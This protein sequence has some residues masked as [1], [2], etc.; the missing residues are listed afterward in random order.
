MRESL[1]PLELVL[2][3]K[4]NASD[5]R[6]S[7]ISRTATPTWT[8]IPSTI[9]TRERRT[10][11][12]TGPQTW[13]PNRR[14]PTC[15]PPPPSIAFSAVLYTATSRSAPPPLCTASGPSISDDSKRQWQSNIRSR[16]VGSADSPNRWRGR[17]QKT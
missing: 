12:L 11:V 6:R 8:S 10:Y 7:E 16:V 4:T 15:L 3:Q 1:R 14:K 5:V 9:L 13:R 2:A 17:L